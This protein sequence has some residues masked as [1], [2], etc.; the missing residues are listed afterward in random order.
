MLTFNI[1]VS[2]EVLV[3]VKHIPYCGQEELA[4]DV[5]SIQIDELSQCWEVLNHPLVGGCGV[6]L[7]EVVLHNSMWQKP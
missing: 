4:F 7:L 1:V 6:Q 2:T 5:G 3:S